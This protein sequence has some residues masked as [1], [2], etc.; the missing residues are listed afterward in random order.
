MPDRKHR[1][2]EQTLPV[3]EDDGNPY[4]PPRL[5][6]GLPSPEE[7]DLRLLAQRDRSLRFGTFLLLPISGVCFLTVPFST[8]PVLSLPLWALLFIACMMNVGRID[9]LGQLLGDGLLFRTVCGFSMLFPLWNFLVILFM[10]SRSSRIL[11]AA[12]HQPGMFGVDP[13]T[14]PLQN[15]P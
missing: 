11:R 15:E 7:I 4:A 12:G 10:V 13:N 1:H 3:Y 8:E 2:Q 6:D 9:L 5:D 14:I